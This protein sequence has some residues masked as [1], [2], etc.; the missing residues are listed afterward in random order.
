M[1]TAQSMNAFGVSVD[2]I[3]TP[4]YIFRISGLLHAFRR[5]L[6][7]EH[8]FSSEQVLESSEYCTGSVMARYLPLKRA[9]ADAVANDARQGL[10][11]RST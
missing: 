8:S 1:E 2:V 9:Q 5:E 6:G 4:K 3:A 10:S 11:R 7:V